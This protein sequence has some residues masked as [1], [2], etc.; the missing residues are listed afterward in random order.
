MI[1]CTDA[2]TFF[3]FFLQLIVQNIVN[4][5]KWEIP[6]LKGSGNIPLPDKNCGIHSISINETN[7][8]IATG[9]I[10]PNS[11]GIYRLPSLEPI[12]LG[13]VSLILN[14]KYLLITELV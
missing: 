1:N 8:K 13:E 4:Q 9:A 7:T 11:T 6:L 12:C 5:A 10:N 2:S 14:F 3:L